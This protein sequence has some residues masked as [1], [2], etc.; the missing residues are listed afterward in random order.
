M[1]EYKHRDQILVLVG[2]KY[3]HVLPPAPPQGV[4]MR[5]NGQTPESGC[6]TCNEDLLIQGRWNLLAFNQYNPR[7]T[8]LIST[9]SFY[10]SAIPL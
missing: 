2:C 3:I 7:M 10:L 4:P 9:D 5:C 8:D 6:V 1:L